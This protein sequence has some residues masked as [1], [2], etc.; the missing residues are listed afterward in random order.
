M[1]LGEFDI[2]ARYFSRTTPRKDVLLGVGDDAA[3]LVPAAGQA[4][5]AAT[6]TLVEGRHFLPGTPAAALGHQA[7]AVNLSDLAA[8][9]AEPAWALLSL[10]LPAADESWIAGFATG[11]Y[12]LAER[13]GVAL[14]GGDTVSGPL[15]VTVEVLGFVPPDVALR[16]SG[17]RTGDLICVSG[18]PGV[19]AAGL[20]ELQAGRATFEAK[21]P[22]VQR[23]LRA[24]PRLAL[25][26]A[27]RGVATAAMDVSDGLL[28]DLRKLA[29]AS[30]VRACIDLERLPIAEELSGY[31][32][33]EQERLVLHGG[34]DYELLFTLPSDHFGLIARLA[35]AGG[36]SVRCIGAMTAGAGVECRREGAAIALEGTGFDHFAR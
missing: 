34:D 16:R 31:P 28:G 2:I 15:V 7:L 30:G 36:C 19:S 29:R 18:S 14:V 22:R 6:D 26:R 32:P 1:P 5:V 13:H 27:L 12:G 24:E 8:M 21:D 9:G 4:L 35:Q 10:S 11:L 23:F 3:L 25:G 33:A 20:A 17:A